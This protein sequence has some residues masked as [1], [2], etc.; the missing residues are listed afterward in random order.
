MKLLFRLLLVMALCGAGA[1]A[2]L[3]WGWQPAPFA[4]GSASAARL[5]PGPLAVQTLELRL[6][7]SSRPTAANGD[8]PGAGERV[9]DASLWYPAAA[10]TAPYPLLVY[11]HGFSATRH[12]GAY[13]ARHLASLGFV[14][15]AMDFP[16]THFG[17]PGGPQ[18]RDVVNQPGDVSFVIDRLL[19]FADTPGHALEGRVDPDRIGAFGLS[20]GGLTTELVAFH[21]RWRDPRIGAALSIAGP[22]YLMTP[23]F[24]QTAPELPFLMLAGDI[25]AL[26]PY[27]SNAAPIPDKMPGA[28]LVTIHGASHTGFAGP[29]AWLRWMD[30]PDVLGCFMVTRSLEEA[31]AEPW[32]DLLGTP[33]QGIDLTADAG[34][35][36]LDPLP[37]A[38]NVLRQQMITRVV[39]SSFFQREYSSAPAERR[40]SARYLREEMARELDEVAYRAEPG[41]AEPGRTQPGRTEPQAG[42]VVGAAP[43]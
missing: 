2:A 12:G 26:V 22:S 20:L 23:V 16:L 1:W 7:D 31:R 32:S 28:E 18:A 17:A 36:Q 25:D 15:V 34:T 40:A 11:S 14:V 3:T 42:E 24:F 6:T 30:N 38:V 33:E 43:R 5:H 4:A 10:D 39:V 35:C 8:Y 9:L 13:L 27:G 37:P 41:R 21:P 19:A 29:A